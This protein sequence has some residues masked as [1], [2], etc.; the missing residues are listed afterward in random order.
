MIQTL[1][2]IW[3]ALRQHNLDRILEVLTNDFPV[4]DNLR[5]YASYHDNQ[6]TVQS[7]YNPNNDN[8]VVE[9]KRI[10]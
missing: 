9:W 4:C 1:F 5:V 2:E 8:L 10:K 7:A 6:H 3:K